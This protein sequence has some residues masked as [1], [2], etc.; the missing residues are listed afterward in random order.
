MM[1]LVNYFHHDVMVRRMH[2]DPRI[3]SVE[4]LLQEQIP[5][6]PPV[7]NPFTGEVK[8]IQRL[9]TAPVEVNPW[10]VPVQTAIP[11]MNLLSNGDYGVLISN[12]G[13]GYSTWRG[14]DLTRW[15]ADP[16][17]DPWGSWIYIQ[18]MKAKRNGKPAVGK[19]W[20]T[21][22]QPI[23]GD[24]SNMQVTYFAHMA[25][26]RRTENG[27]SSTME[28]TVAP[29]DPVE[30][31]RVHL[32]NMS[33]HS[34]RLRLTSYGEVI[35]TQQAG[36][37][38]HPAFNKLF[39]ESEYVP[40][41]NLQIF[42]RRLRSKDEKPVYLGHMLVLES[43][44]GTNPSRPDARHES[45]R[46]QFIGRGKS[47]RN[48]AV[49]NSESYLQGT[50]GA[51]L[52]PIFS[53]GQEVEVAPHA[54]AELAYLTFV[55]ESREAVLA[56]AARYSLWPL[57]D[58]TFRQADISAQSW[59]GKQ[60]FDTQT[61]KNTLQVLSVLQ[62]PFKVVRAS[63]ET[64]ASNRLGQSGLWRF[65]ISGDYPIILLEI[66]DAKQVDLVR[67]VLGVQE[68]LRNRRFMADVV[69]LNKQRTEYGAELNGILYRTVTRLNCEDWL[70]QRGGIF[71]LYADQINPEET[72]L[73]QTAGRFIFK[74]DQGTLND[75]M[76]GIPIPGASF[77]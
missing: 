53:L 20:S 12:M 56:L 48:P 71:I 19:T 63:P 24:P 41:Y 60:N 6:A 3:Q 57:I 4:L 22:H 18:E 25:V 67:E 32:L 9:V 13:S 14:I 73:L 52:D 10:N 27:I 17:L 46:S 35:L 39:I 58:R 38:R 44:D 75:Q 49:L 34:S 43:M 66:D 28:V 1:A 64:I 62:Y 47:L 61:L 51:T 72:A 65:G 36:D 7:Q 74:G 77:T 45:D 50:T 68:F 16:V 40:E 54:N 8:G 31:R 5:Q 33:N 37:T 76:P 42:T 26:Y 11:Q 23:P 15:Q 30:I 29:D 70:N 59:L 21:G 55:G 2:S 69:L